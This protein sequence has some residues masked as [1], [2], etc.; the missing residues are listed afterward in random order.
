MIACPCCGFENIEGVDAC[1]SCGQEMTSL[2]PPEP[3][4]AVERGLLRDRVSVLR[5]KTPVTVGPNASVREVLRTLANRGIGCVMIVENER[6]VGIFSERDALLKLNTEAARLVDRPISEFMTRDPQS[7]PMDAKVAFA[8][9]RMDQGSFRHVPI[10]DKEHR[11]V[12]V[13][14]ARDILAYLTDKMNA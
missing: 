11:P 1:D 9:H 14:S 10:V 2:H 7:L 12:G 5:P 6:L 13:I 3:A 4:T 8:V